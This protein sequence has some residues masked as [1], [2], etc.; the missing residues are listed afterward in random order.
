MSGISLNGGLERPLCEAV[1][2]KPGLPWR[3][4]NVGDARAI[5]YLSRRAANREWN[6]PK[7]KKCVSV[8]KAERSW[9]SEEYFDIRHSI[10]SLEFV[11]LV[12]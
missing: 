9:R 10:Q 11:Q 8:N 1:K 3:P 2:L 4:Q 7:R 5:G 6:Q 12:F